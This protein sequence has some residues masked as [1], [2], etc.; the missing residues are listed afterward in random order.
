MLEE[1]HVCGV[2]GQA[3][4]GGGNPMS[5]AESE[6]VFFVVDWS[7][8]PLVVEQY[9]I[10]VLKSGLRVVL[11]TLPGMAEGVAVNRAAEAVGR[12]LSPKGE[13]PQRHGKGRGGSPTLPG[14]A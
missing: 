3:A 7:A 14:L 1:L 13:A 12:V 11:D 6:A 2:Y 4:R 10:R 8:Y 5:E 9:R